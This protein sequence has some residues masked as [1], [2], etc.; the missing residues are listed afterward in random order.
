MLYQAKINPQ[1]DRRTDTRGGELPVSL[2]ELIVRILQLADEL[3]LPVQL[4]RSASVTSLGFG[5]IVVSDIEVP[6]M[7]ANMV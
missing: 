4:G 3:C 2:R 1:P 6:N 5:R 7:L